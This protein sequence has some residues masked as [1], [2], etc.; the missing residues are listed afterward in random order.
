MT[1][2]V[3]HGFVCLLEQFIVSLKLFQ[4]PDKQGLTR[5]PTKFK[6]NVKHS[7]KSLQ[8]SFSAEDWTVATIIT[9]E[10]FFK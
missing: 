10:T 2:R 5:K 1:R 6:H 3:L 7:W 4:F 8:F 9:E